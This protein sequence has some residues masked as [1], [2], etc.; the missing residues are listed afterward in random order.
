MNSFAEV[1][2]CQLA[3][4]AVDQEYANQDAV[5]ERHKQEIEQTYISPS[6]QLIIDWNDNESK[7]P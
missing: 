7:Q 6:D 2:L 5:I 3:G 4:K 1:G